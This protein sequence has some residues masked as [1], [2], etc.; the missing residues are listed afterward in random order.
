MRLMV[1]ISTLTQDQFLHIITFILSARLNFLSK[2]H[3][4]NCPFI[5]IFLSGQSKIFVI[6]SVNAM[7]YVCQLVRRTR[8]CSLH[9]EA[10]NYRSTSS[11]LN[12]R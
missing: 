8:G 10:R 9:A 1:V 12:T 6:V 2:N 3:L 11:N 4:K 7:I 5:Y